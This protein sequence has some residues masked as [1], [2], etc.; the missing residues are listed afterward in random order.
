V[1]H[2]PHSLQ[3]YQD[4]NTINLVG[5]AQAAGN[6]IK[7]TIGR[8]SSLTFTSEVLSVWARLCASS[9][10]ISRM[11]AA[12]EAALYVHPKLTAI[13]TAS[14]NGGDFAALMEAR[15]RPVK[16]PSSGSSSIGPTKPS[17][18]RAGQ[19]HSVGAAMNDR[20]A[21]LTIVGRCGGG[22][23]LVSDRVA[24]WEWISLPRREPSRARSGWGPSTRASL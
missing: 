4:S 14:M 23:R 11:R 18:H 21:G 19:G 5:A 9:R 15:I 24:S 1:T 20:E 6:G 16:L 22:L 13:A 8:V 2:T 17:R 3:P 7:S 12:V 10:T